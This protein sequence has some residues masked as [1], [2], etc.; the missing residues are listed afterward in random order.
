MVPGHPGNA[1]DRQVPRTG[2]R[3]GV[4]EVQR[5]L[6]RVQ[7]HASWAANSA[8]LQGLAQADDATATSVSGIAHQPGGVIPLVPGVGRHPLGK[9]CEQSRVVG[10]VAMDAHVHQIRRLL[11]GQGQRLCDV[12]LDAA[13]IAAYPRASA[14]SDGRRAR[15]PLTTMQ[16]SVAPV[17]AVCTA[18]S[19]RLRMSSHAAHRGG[20]SPDCEQVTV[21]RAAAGLHRHDPLDLDVRPDRIRTS[22]ILTTRRFGPRAG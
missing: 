13:W 9:S 8:L 14:P 12:D 16:N 5:H 22:W 19:T 20:K 10:F 4:E 7:R 1:H 6:V 15:A 2:C 17:A 3:V 11:R 21:R 18:A